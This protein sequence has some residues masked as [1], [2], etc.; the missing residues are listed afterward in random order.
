MFNTVALMLRPDQIRLF[1]ALF[2]AL[3]SVAFSAV[4]RRLRRILARLPEQGRN[5]FPGPFA[6]VRSGPIVVDLA[7]AVAP[8]AAL[9]CGWIADRF[10]RLRCLWTRRRRLAPPH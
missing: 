7:A 6:R 2:A 4:A 10:G 5:D 8:E 9:S 1:V 3:V